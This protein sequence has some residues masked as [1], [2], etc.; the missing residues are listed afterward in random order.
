M[1]I[2]IRLFL[3]LC[4]GYVL[5]LGADQPANTYTIQTVAGTDSVGDGSAA[6][7]ALFSQTEG[8]AVDRL[9]NIYV[10]DADNNRVRM[11]VPGGTITTWRA[12]E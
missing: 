7:S 12:R 11:I 2:R 3:L 4:S 1:V 6:L 5:F 9:G 10:A 8:I